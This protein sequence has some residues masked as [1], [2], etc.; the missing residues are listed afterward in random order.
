MLTNQ[1]SVKNA[2]LHNLKN[3]TITLPKNKIIAFTGVSGS[4]KSSLA[5]DLIYEEG[6]KKYLQLIGFS[7]YF[8]LEKHYD[9]IT[10]LSPTIA[11]EQR[12]RAFLNPRSTVGTKTGIYNL[13]KQL[14]LLEGKSAKKIEIHDFTFNDPNGWCSACKGLGYLYDFH[15]SKLIRDPNLNLFQICAQG[16]FGYIK[17]ATQALADEFHFELDTPYKMLN[18]EIRHAFL[19]GSHSFPGIVSDL[20]RTL[21]KTASAYRINKIEKE[22]MSKRICAKCNGYRL[23]AKT[24]QVTL[25]G[26]HISQLCQLPLLEL[27]LFLEQRQ[28]ITGEGK[29]VAAEIVV[30]AQRSALAGIGYLDLNRSMTTLSG[31]EAQR[32]D[33]MSYLNSDL[34]SLVFVLDEPSMGLHEQ[35]KAGLIHLLK[36]MNRLG[37]T[38]IIVEHDKKLICEADLVIE[39][40]PGA[41][42]LGGS[43]VYQGTANDLINSD[44][45]LTG[46]Y[47]RYSLGGKARKIRQTSEQ[48]IKIKGAAT[49]NLKNIDVDIPL[50]ILVGIMGPSGCGKSSLISDTLVPLLTNCL[51]SDIEESSAIRGDE[52]IG[53]LCSSGEIKALSVISQSPISRMK[54]SIPVSYIGIWDEIRKIY[55]SLPESKRHGY[56]A[57]HFSFNSKEGG[58]IGCKGA[59]FKEVDVTFANKI[60]IPCKACRCTGYQEEILDIKYQGYSIRELLNLSITEALALFKETPKIYNVLNLLESIGMGYIT[61]GQPITTLSGG[62]AQRIKLAKELSKKNT[63]NRLIILDE[64]TTGLHD[65]D[66]EKLLVILNKL[67][68]EGNSILI[69]EHN[70]DVLSQCDYLI[71]LGPGG[72]PNGGE[73]IAQGTVQAIINN[74]RSITGKYLK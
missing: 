54:T 45:S 33:L 46:Q 69:V 61:L 30:R 34:N 24:L 21:R 26:Q 25:E 15:E 65:A 29:A 36:E 3:V 4:G 58:C 7:D 39:M 40:G 28:Y 57:G 51:V 52:V 71:E 9:E 38:I 19:Y 55:S 22:F 13:L 18:D 16:A 35:E 53:E 64:P 42:R 12:T 59:G 14:F 6:R 1:I 27:S 68:D 48:W 72:G 67:V 63:S 11:V 41:G 23:K 56:T 5:F 32:L 37:N 60:E 50:G 44:V 74:P 43:I 17:N 66:I 62:E 70:I 2:Y 49:N 10:G 31:G 20:K 73:V 47:L 8:E